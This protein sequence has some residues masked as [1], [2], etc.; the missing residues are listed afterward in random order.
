M[1][2]SAFDRGCEV[3]CEFLKLLKYYQTFFR[4]KLQFIASLKRFK[5][6]NFF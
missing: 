1:N 3:S 5:D 4:V 6:F 2:E